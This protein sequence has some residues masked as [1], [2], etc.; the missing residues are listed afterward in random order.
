MT[1]LSLCLLAP[2]TPSQSASMPMLMLV[3]ISVPPVRD[4]ATYENLNVVF[5]MPRSSSYRPFLLPCAGRPRIKGQ[6]FGE[7]KSAMGV[8]VDWA[9][10]HTHTALLSKQAIKHGIKHWVNN[11]WQLRWAKLA[12]CQQTKVWFPAMANYLTQRYS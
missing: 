4:S 8:G 12:T 10:V 9:S 1:T 7:K 6:K 2:S 3:S 5:R 11:K